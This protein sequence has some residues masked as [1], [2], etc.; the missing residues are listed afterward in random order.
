MADKSN[1]TEGERVSVMMTLS[2]KGD[3]KKLEEH[4]A[5]N[6][7]EMQGI[8]EAAKGHGLI[9]HRFYGTDDGEIMV[10]DEWPDEQSFR[11]FF[12]ENSGRIGP[13]MRAAGVTAEPQ[14][15][16]WHKLETHDEYGWGA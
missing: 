7:A 11:S 16:I 5:S 9:A 4:A 6:S 12:E 14:P 1:P 2:V 8:L 15:K 3:P 13:M 10:V